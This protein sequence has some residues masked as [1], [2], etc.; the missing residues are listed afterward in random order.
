M[1]LGLS[2]RRFISRGDIFVNGWEISCLDSEECTQM[3]S[4]IDSFINRRHIDQRLGELCELCGRRKICNVCQV[5][6]EKKV[7]NWFRTAQV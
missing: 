4:S 6:E 7:L 3:S 2:A 1:L 5:E